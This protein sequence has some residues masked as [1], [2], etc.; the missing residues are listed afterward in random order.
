MKKRVRE[1]TRRTPVVPPAIL[2]PLPAL[3]PPELAAMAEQAF[4]G[5]VRM[6]GLTLK[7][8]NAGM[9]GMAF[10]VPTGLSRQ[11]S[12]A[13]ALSAF[14]QPSTLRQLVMGRMVLDPPRALDRAP[15]P[16]S[17]TF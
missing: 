5:S 8:R 7:M 13:M 11:G 16:Y 4:A 12:P 15:V 14:R 1:P 2:P 6:P 9:A 10:R 3:P 17:P